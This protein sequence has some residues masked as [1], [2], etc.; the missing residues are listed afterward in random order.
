MINN[1][2]LRVADVNSWFSGFGPD[3]SIDNP[4]STFTDY[5]GT[6]LTFITLLSV[7]FVIYAGVLYVTSAGDDTKVKKAQGTMTYA[8]IGLIVSFVAGVIVRLVL[9]NAGAI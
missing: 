2:V 8:I 3:V 9:S 4:V 1:F 5:M 6:A 7:G